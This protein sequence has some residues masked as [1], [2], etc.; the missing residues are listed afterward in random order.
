MKIPKFTPRR[1]ISPKDN[2]DF[3]VSEEA[4][5]AYL[6]KEQE[7]QASK[8]T[9]QSAI[10]KENMRNAV[11]SWKR[12]SNDSGSSEVQIVR[13]NERI[14]YLTSHMLTQKKDVA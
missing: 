12:N 2:P 10:N 3:E 8:P 6:E 13:V 4:L 11:I 7:R 1:R 5:A 9:P 14:K